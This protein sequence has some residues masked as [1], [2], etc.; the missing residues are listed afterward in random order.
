VNPPL[1]DPPALVTGQT[2]L[3]DGV[4]SVGAT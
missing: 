3:V 4:I 2:L 1:I